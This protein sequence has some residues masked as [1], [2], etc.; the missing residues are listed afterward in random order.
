MTEILFYHLERQPLERVL[1]VLLEKTLSRGWRA[2]VQAGGA[3]RVESLSTLLWTC[4]DEAFLPHGTAR[5]GHE[6]HQPIWLTA[7]P[8]NPNRADIRFFVDGSNSEDIADY[9]RVAHLFDGRD[10]TL[11]ARLRDYWKAACADGHNAT[12]WQQNRA[13]VW[14]QKARS[15]E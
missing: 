13:G 15:G 4:R 5:D 1:P 11:L 9:R 2:V 3:E 12:Y 6:A 14:E 8:V 7:E 10:A